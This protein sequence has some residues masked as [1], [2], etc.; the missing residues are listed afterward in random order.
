MAKQN[1][2]MAPLVQLPVVMTPFKRLA[3]HLVGQ[4]PRTK[5]GAK[6]LLTSME[7]S[8]LCCSPAEK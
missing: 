8:S 4:L 6:Y 2:K 3:I 5:R 1:H 7:Q